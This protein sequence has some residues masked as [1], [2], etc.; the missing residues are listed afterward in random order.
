MQDAECGMALGG[1]QWRTLG[2]FSPAL[3]RPSTA[4]LAKPDATIFASMIYPQIESRLRRR[5]PSG[6]ERM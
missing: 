3:P 2:G 1:P 6:R 4:S 5:S